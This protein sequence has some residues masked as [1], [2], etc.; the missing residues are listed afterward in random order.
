MAVKKPFT[1]NFRTPAD[2]LSKEE[3]NKLAS[4]GGRGNLVEEFRNAL[5]D[6]TWESEQLAKSQGIY[7]EF[8]RARTG[9]EKDW[10]YMIRVSVTGGGPLTRK[11]WQI[12]DDLAEKHTADTE[13]V[14]SI[15][16]TNRQNIQFHWIKKPA[17]VE[18]VRSIAEAGWFTLNGCGDNTRNVMGC[19]L[20]QYSEVFNA[21][22][23]AHKAG[24]YFRLP[25]DPFI[26]IFS[27]DPKFIRKPEESFKYGPNLLNRKFKIAFASIH[28]D[29]K[30]EKF[31]LDNCVEHRTHDLSVAP[32]LENGKITKFQVY[33]GGGQ[34]ERNGKP[35]MAVL[36]LPLC[37]CTGE[38]LMPV[39][40]AAVQVHQEYGDRQNRFW[41]RLKYVIKKMGADWYRDQVSAKVGFPLEK[42]NPTYDSGPRHLH[43]G[44]TY[45]AANDLWAYGLYIENGRI[46]DKGTNGQVRKLIRHLMDTYP[47][48]LY[49][50]PNQ[51]ALFTN[52][53]E[54]VKN[55]FEADVA[56]FGCDK[57]NGK[58]FSRLRLNSGACVGLDT[59]RLSYTESEKFEPV[60]L[61]QLE[62][63]GWGE[64]N[65]S[66]GITGCERQCFR[67]AT[68]TIG[69]V[70]SGA[71]RYQLKLGGSEDGRNQ[72]LPLAASDGSGIYLRSIPREKV[73]TVIDA[74]FKHY[75]AHAKPNE[76][77]GAFHRRVG[78]DK[79]ISQL[80]AD[81]ATA[82]LMLKPFPSDCVID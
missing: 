27:I 79:I 72:G 7:L 37:Q 26:Q 10:R 69:L 82:D 17:C 52:I 33:V 34:G 80:K 73:P 62:A 14:P 21:H 75:K 58:P 77:L 12:I 22:A 8:D 67:P 45:Q 11:Q 44:W 36:G 55:N 76:D 56:R 30:T 35:S 59:C 6:L 20:S 49:I 41:A 78:L 68:K 81:P 42:P 3:L 51:D 31:T 74:L 2:Q 70:G 53:P 43:H 63:M 25:M 48:E 9:E 71:D 4:R 39:L 16:F 54:S 66:V 47:V 28:K 15:R 46:K 23:W 50:T 61:D 57:R 18:I 40:D 29:P 19:P 65:E 60:L 5:P 64:L 13:G 24:S 32:I 38:Q 1:P